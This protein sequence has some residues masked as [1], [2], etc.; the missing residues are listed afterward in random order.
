M[1]STGR[2]FSNYPAGLDGNNTDLSNGISKY[3]VAELVSGDAERPYP[4]LEMNSPP[5]GAINKSSYPPT[6]VNYADRLIGVQSVVVDSADRLWILD[7]GRAIDPRSQMLTLA[8]PGGPKL[9]GVDLKSDSIFE[10]ITFPP[11]VAYPDSY[12]NDVRFDLRPNQSALSGTKGVAYI[13]DSSTEGRN[14][15]VVVDLSNGRSWRHLNN[16]PRVRPSEQV[17][18][19]VWGEPLYTVSSPGMPFSHIGFGSDGIAL[20]A[21]GNDLYFKTLSGRYLYSIP[22]ERLRD[23]GA[24]SEVLA[25]SAVVNRGESGISDGLETDSN[26]LVYAGNVEQESISF[27]YPDNGTVNTFVRDPRINWVDTSKSSD[28]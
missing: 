24:T 5:G 19:Y 20:S 7:T 26:G 23:N 28:M 27:Y 4:S 22:T 12:L 3:Q 14:G 17:V 2:K 21:D 15:I 16:D 18:P 1:S 13:T 9:I 10:T 8:A 6:S 11:T 25:Q